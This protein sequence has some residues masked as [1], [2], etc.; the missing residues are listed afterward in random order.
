[1]FSQLASERGSALLFALLLTGMLTLIGL[2]AIDNSTTDVDLSYNQSAADAAFYNA[3]AG[4]KRAF[5]TIDNDVDW[6]AG[7]S[8]VSFGGG[9][10]SVT[11]IDS[12]VQAGLDD[13][14]I[15]LSTGV[16]NGASAQVRVELLPTYNYPFSFAMFADES[17]LMENN[18]CTDSYNSDSGSYAV[19]QANDHGSIGSNGTITLQDAS[20]VG[21]DAS[22][23]TPGGITI[24]G[25]SA[26]TGDTSSTVDSVSMDIIPDSE[27]DWAAANNNAPSGFSGSNFNWN[28]GNNELIIGEGGELELSGGVYYFSYIKIEEDSEIRLAPGAEVTIYLDGDMI[29]ENESYLNQGGSPSDLLIFSRGSSLK[30]ENDSEFY[31]AFYGPNAEFKIENNTSLYGAV[32]SKRI[33]LENDA[34]FHYDRNLANIKKGQ[35]DGYQ[36]VAW[37]E[38]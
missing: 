28:A 11:V 17:I 6:R 29:M 37:Q 12:S 14:V 33:I 36:M 26:V 15:L 20:T 9:A 25:G 19:T 22:S 16:R 27:Y 5:V 34:C 3:E 32:A 13:T 7:F 21:G 4:A 35:G 23:A 1:M 2:M 31:G 30:L 38:L 10:Y 24:D 18:T 8:A